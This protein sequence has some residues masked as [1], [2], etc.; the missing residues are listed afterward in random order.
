MPEGTGHARVHLGNDDGGAPGGRQCAI[1][2]DPERAQTVG[3]RGRDVDEGY[4]E[5]ERPTGLEQ[6]RDF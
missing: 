4:I 6:C 1:D 5:R 3:V 2:R